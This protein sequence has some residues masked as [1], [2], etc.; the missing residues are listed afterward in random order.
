MLDAGARDKRVMAI[1][2]AMDK[3]IGLSPFKAAYPARF[4]D[5]GIAEEHA[6]TFAAGLAAQGLRPVVAV[7]ST[8]MQ[9]AVD[10]VI[11][12]VAIQKLPVTFALDRAGFV[13]DDGETHQG[14]FDIALFRSVPNM[15]ILAPAGAGELIRMVDWALSSAGPAMLRYPKAPCPPES[16]AFSLPLEPG[17]GVFIRE[18]GASLC[19]AFTGSLYAEVWDAADRLKDAD[20]A[21]DLYNLRFLHPVDEDYLADILNHYEMVVVIEEGMKRGGFGEYVAELALRR[22]CKARLLTLGV[23]GYFIPQ[24]KREELL[25]LT[26]LDGAGIARS[27]LQAWRKDLKEERTKKER[28]YIMEAMR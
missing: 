2:A 6:V 15:S 9:R 26:G 19:L 11:H 20:V 18:W 27:V 8:F 16:R 3:G 10:Q 13:G 23:P 12:D 4:F 25:R 14:L 17:R 1:T 24:G 5:V 28:P 22:R 21:T 7:Y